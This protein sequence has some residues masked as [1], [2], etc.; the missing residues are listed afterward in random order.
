[1]I[2]Y[3][4]LIDIDDP[5]VPPSDPF[6][7]TLYTKSKLDYILQNSDPQQHFEEI[8]N[9]NN[10]KPSKNELRYTSDNEKSIVA[11]DPDEVTNDNSK[12]LP[13]N[14][15]N[16]KLLKVIAGAH[17]GWVRS[18][19]VDPVTNEWFVTGSSDSTIKVWD[20]ASLKCKATIS[21][22]IMAV[23]AL[24]ISKRYPYLFSGSEDKTVR[25]FDL[26]RSNSPLGCQIRNYHGHLG[27]IYAMALHP[28]LD[29]LF[30][31]GKDMSLRAW[32]IRS[33]A[34]IMTLTGHKNDITSIIASESDPQIITCSMDGTIRLWDLRKQSTYL[35]LTHHTKSIRLLIDHPNESTICS[36]DSLGNI[37]QWV[38]PSGDLLNEFGSSKK[39]INTMAINHTNNNLF[40][41]YDSGEFEIY[42]YANGESLQTGKTIPSPGSNESSI[43][44]STFDLLGLR[45]ITGEGDNSIKIWGE[46]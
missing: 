40:T 13:K 33:R 19:Q 46:S 30:T 44:C 41:G 20:L 9:S 16:Y 10:L 42:D 15:T 26:E 38:M 8:D 27:G 25:C 17:Q 43:Y 21:G 5:I 45:L 4:D 36:G 29:I 11:V 31:G 18:L 3:K 7:E 39:I 14:I 35:T 23:R 2:N 1:M 24:A 32:D 34:E 37:K 12:A 22:H 28:E 6:S